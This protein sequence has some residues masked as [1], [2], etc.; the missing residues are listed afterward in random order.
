MK[1]LAFTVLF[2]LALVGCSGGGG[3]LGAVCE[4]DTDCSE[5]LIC[6]AH[7]EGSTCQEPHGH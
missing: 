7:D 3:E 1:L 5:G 2:S 4:V 6:D